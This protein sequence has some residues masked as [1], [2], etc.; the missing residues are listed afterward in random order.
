MVAGLLMQEMTIEL[1][2]SG[3]PSLPPTVNVWQAGRLLHTT[4][5]A[6]AKRHLTQD[7]APGE[8]PATTAQEGDKLSTR[9][10]NARP[11]DSQEPPAWPSVLQL[12]PSG[13]SE[14]RASVPTR[15][16]VEG[17]YTDRDQENRPG[18]G[19]D[20]RLTGWE[21]KGLPNLYERQ[22]GLIDG[23][24]GVAYTELRFPGLQS[25]ESGK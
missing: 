15:I 3:D 4:T 18:V 13:A 9:H 20:Q 21:K 1:L 8:P 2:Q 23:G 24:I 16:I 11:G 22:Q 7:P 14:G 19:G 10:S 17:F 25:D 12:R 5:S 6:S